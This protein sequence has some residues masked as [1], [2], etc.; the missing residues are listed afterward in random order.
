MVAVGAVAVRDGAILLVRRGNPPEAG[1]WS[2]PGGRVQLGETVSAAVRR[3]LHEETG[4]QGRVGTLRG[5]AERITEHFHYLIL[6]FDVEV[7]PGRAPTAASDAVDAA[8]VALRELDSIELVSGL[9]EFL[10]G[11]GVIE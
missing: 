10:R 7:E 8:W 2:L 9:V 11:S 4:L 1:R 3:E 6:D 5:W